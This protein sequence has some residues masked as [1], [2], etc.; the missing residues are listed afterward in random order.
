MVRNCPPVCQQWLTSWDE[1]L[2]IRQIW[3]LRMYQ[4]SDNLIG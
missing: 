4:Q 2:D 3:E 1:L